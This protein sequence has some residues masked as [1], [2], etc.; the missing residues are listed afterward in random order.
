[1]LAEM[2][3][4]HLT[5]APLA[6]SA[7][8]ALPL[9]SELSAAFM[10]VPPG[11][12]WEWLNA[13]ASEATELLAGASSSPSPA[14]A[15]LTAL[16]LP[17]GAPCALHIVRSATWLGC[18]FTVVLHCAGVVTPSAKEEAV[19]QR[20]LAALLPSLL[21]PSCPQPL[22]AAFAIWWG[23]LPPALA[24]SL[25][26]DLAHGLRAENVLGGKE[27]CEWEDLVL[28]PLALLAC[29]QVVWGSPPLVRCTMR[30]F[31]VVLM[32]ILIY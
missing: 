32:E 5:G 22:Q 6:A 28:A 15:L 19:A 14:I 30:A 3:P 16:C 2:A 1:M 10:R 9:S 7:L 21:T 23:R 13:N 24:R 20:M 29:R 26:P 31:G 12:A 4:R 27:V 11:A 25:A 18:A 17:A 8:P